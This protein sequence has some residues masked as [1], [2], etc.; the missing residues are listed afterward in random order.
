[1]A[2]AKQLA[3]QKRFAMRAKRGDFRKAITKTKK[4]NFDKDY[5]MICHTCGKKGDLS[6]HNKRHKIGSQARSYSVGAEETAKA[7]GQQRFGESPFTINPKKRNSSIAK[8]EQRIADLEEKF[9]QKLKHYDD[10]D[11]R[12]LDFEGD[13]IRKTRIKLDD[14]LKRQ[15]KY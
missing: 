13:Q 12:E 4:S 8:L 9:H 7:M 1:M 5:E 11:S 6:K 14:E 3:N 10:Y 2:S 15:M